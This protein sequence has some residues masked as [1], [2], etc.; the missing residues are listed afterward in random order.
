MRLLPTGQPRAYLR[1]CFDVLSV[2]PPIIRWRARPRSHYP[3]DEK[4]E[5]AWRMQHKTFAGFNIRPD[6]SKRMRVPITGKGVFHIKS[7]I[8]EIGGVTPI[9]RQVPHLRGVATRPFQ[10]DAGG[11]RNRAARRRLAGR[12]GRDGAHAGRPDGHGR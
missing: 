10:R 1:E 3:L 11:R 7:I 2:D 9:D 8:A 6:T 5:M 4:G 12:C